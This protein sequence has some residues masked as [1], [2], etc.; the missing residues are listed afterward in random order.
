MLSDDASQ[1]DRAM[2]L[3]HYGAKAMPAVSL[4]QGEPCWYMRLIQRLC[5]AS[6]SEMGQT[7]SNIGNGSGGRWVKRSQ[8]IGKKLSGD[9]DSRA[10]ALP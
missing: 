9:D 7:G 6:Q 3:P 8:M 2:Q 5:Q 10:N 1:W 4:D